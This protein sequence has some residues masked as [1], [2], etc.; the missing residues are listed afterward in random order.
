MQTIFLTTKFNEFFQFELQTV[1]SSRAGI[2]ALIFRQMALSLEHTQLLRCVRR[3]F[4]WKLSLLCLPAPYDCRPCSSNA[5][6][7]AKNNFD[8]VAAAALPACLFTRPW[9][10]TALDLSISTHT[11]AESVPMCVC[12]RECACVLSSSSTYANNFATLTVF[13]FVLAYRPNFCVCCVSVPCAVHSF[14]RKKGRHNKQ[15]EESKV[16]A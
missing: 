5:R 8:A 4:S 3:A 12:V 14:S 16:K 13:P 7:K 15:K 2:V 11:N 10:R 1:E 6:L 9:P